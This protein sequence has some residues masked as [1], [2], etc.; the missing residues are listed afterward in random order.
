MKPQREIFYIEDELDLGKAFV[1]LF[2]DSRVKITHFSDPEV[3]LKKISTNPPDL[4]FI[5]YRLEKAT[6]Q[7]V[8]HKIPKHIPKVL[9][10][11][12]LNFNLDPVFT[13]ILPKPFDVKLVKQIIDSICS[14]N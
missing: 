13:K 6:G 10:T 3:A 7:E 8:A 2:T 12:E 11:G 4:I 5:D 1:E 14:K 9:I